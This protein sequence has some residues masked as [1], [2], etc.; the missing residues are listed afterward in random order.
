MVRGGVR[1]EGMV[2][3]TGGG[4]SGGGD[5]GTFWVHSGDDEIWSLLEHVS[6]AGFSVRER[7]CWGGGLCTVEAP[8]N[9]SSKARFIG[10]EAKTVLRLSN[11]VLYK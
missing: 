2:V 9:G 3:W 11:M 1:Q 8:V 10:S 4:V 7:E 6:S 5:V